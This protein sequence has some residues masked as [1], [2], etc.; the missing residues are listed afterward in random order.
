MQFKELESEDQ[1]QAIKGSKGY[2]VIF[3]HNTTCPISKSVRRHFEVEAEQLP[4]VEAVY[5]LDLL[6]HRNLSD[7]IA[8]QYNIE[9]ESPQLLLIKEGQCTYHEALYDIS[10]E[11]TSEAIKQQSQS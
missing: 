7:A 3:K 9:H 6:A 2:T 4:Q 1:L 8:E 5:F 11:A 10:A